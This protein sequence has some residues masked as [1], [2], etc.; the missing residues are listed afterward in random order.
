MQALLETW[1]DIVGLINSLS[2]ADLDRPT[3]HTAWTVREAFGHIIDSTEML[4]RALEEAKLGETEGVL[5][6]REMAPEMERNAVER[7]EGMD[8]K[9]L[10]ETFTAVAAR[11]YGRLQE[12]DTLHN[13]EEPVPHPYLG[14]CP[15]V[16]IAGFALLDWFIHP[17]D[18][19]DALGQNPQPNP[20]HAALLVTG[21]VNL[22]PR[23]LDPE[24]AARLDSPAIYRYI[25]ETEPPIILNVTVADHQAKVTPGPTEE[26]S[27]DLV[28]KGK[29]GDLVLAMLG[30]RSPAPLLKRS[31]SE[32]LQRFKSLWISL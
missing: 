25:A 19:R 24:Q 27:A 28:F 6:P 11:L 30:R 2:E 16:Q 20:A 4:A 1:H 17:W 15:A 23:R 3:G 12:R 14:S 7:A 5:R 31:T 10:G 9:A 32:A 8:T 26:D 21:L 22:L 29:P 13:W 18:I